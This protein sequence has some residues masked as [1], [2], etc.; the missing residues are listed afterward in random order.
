MHRKAG[1]AADPFV[2]TAEQGAPTREVDAGLVDVRRELGRR[3][4]QA[5]QDGLLDLGDRLVQG[6]GDFRVAHEDLLRDARHE[7]A[8]AHRI[9]LRRVVELGQGTAHFDLD[10]LGRALTHEDVVL[11]AHVFLDVLGE[12]VTGHA[13]VL[14][15][16]DT[17]EGDDRNL[18]G[19]PA[20]VDDHVAHRLLHINADTDGRSHGLVDQ[21]DLL[22]PGVFGAVLDRPLLD[23]RDARGDAD[24]HAQGRV[25]QA[26]AA[27][28]H[29]DHAFDHVLRALEV[30]DHAVLQGPDRLDV[31]V[32]LT[33][34][35]LGLAPDG[36]GLVGRA[37]L[38]DD[39]RFI[40][41]HLVLVVDH[42]VGRAEIDG[43]LLHE[44]VE[45][46]HC[47][48]SWWINGVVGAGVAEESTRR[49]V[50]KPENRDEPVRI[51]A[52]SGGCRSWPWPD[53]G[54]RSRRH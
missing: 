37:V 17:A 19:T 52:G 5:A 48:Q 1:L 15:G 38:G 53:R 40:H 41:H 20:D 42:R 16:H 3:I 26:P 22:G 23:L 35:L 11:A 33:V 50:N 18:R 39:G 24:D 32:R 46:A 8:A 45:Q 25:E 27:L 6:H 9:I 54:R 2:Q 49:M 30:G 51:N 47:T 7:V 44:E 28:Y 29:P 31:L 36:H 13:D 12:L 4:L 10:L 21:E 14:V 43:D 34:H